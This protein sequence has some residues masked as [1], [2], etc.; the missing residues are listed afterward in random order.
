MA[1][2]NFIF[3]PAVCSDLLLFAYAILS[4]SNIPQLELVLHIEHDG[5]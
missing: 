4:Y 2:I 1:P 3:N 5:G